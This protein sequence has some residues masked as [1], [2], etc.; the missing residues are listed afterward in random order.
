MFIQVIQGYYIE[1]S[2]DIVRLLAKGKATNKPSLLRDLIRQ[3]PAG[4][5]DEYANVLEMAY[6]CCSYEREDR[7]D[8]E[9]VKACLSQSIQRM[10]TVVNSQKKKSNQ[11]PDR[12][13]LQ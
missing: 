5:I 10:T 8:I 4:A 13:I 11:P 6:E 1:D 9:V 7:P 12:C 3:W 2:P